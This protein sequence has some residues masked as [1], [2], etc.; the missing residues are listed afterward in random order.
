[1]TPQPR[2][3]LLPRSVPAALLATFA[4]LG[5]LAGPLPGPALAQVVGS[6]AGTVTDQVGQPLPGVK[7]TVTSPTQIGGAKTTYTNADGAFRVPGLQPGVFDVK[8]EAPKLQTVVQK[9]VVVDVGVPAEVDVLMEV[10]GA[11]EEIT[12]RNQAPLVS[13]TSAKQREAYDPGFIEK[14]PLAGIARNNLFA[15]VA[16]ATPGAQRNGLE[17]RVRGGA[18]QHN[19]ARV[20]GFTLNTLNAQPTLFKGLATME[21]QSA[22]Y[23]AENADTLGSVVDTVTKSGSNRLEFEALAFQDSNNRWSLFREK[24]EQTTNTSRT[25]LHLAASGPIVKDRVWVATAAELRNQLQDHERD[26][27]GLIDTG[28]TRTHRHAR[29]SVKLTW[30]ISPRNKVQSITIYNREGTRFRLTDNNVDVEAQLKWDRVDYLQGVTWES[31]LRDDLFF[32]TQVGV[33]GT[34]IQEYPQSCVSNPG[35][36]LDV[37]AIEQRYPRTLKLANFERVSQQTDRS[38]ELVNTLEWYRN[39]RSFGDHDLKLVSRNRWRLFET[40]QSAPGGRK[41]IYNGRAPDRQI[42]YF[43][44][45]PRLEEPRYGFAIQ[46]GTGSRWN[47]SLQDTV[48]VTRY[49]TAVVGLSAIHNVGRNSQM[50]VVMQGW[51]LTPHLSAIWDATHDGRTALRASVAQ[52]ADADAERIANQALGTGVTRECRWDE[53]TGAFSRD[54]QYAGGRP[55]RTIGLPCGPTGYW[56]DGTPCQEKLR[57]PRTW[58][59]TAGAEREIWNG[60]GAALD[61]V[62]RVF[63]NPFEFRETNRI[64]NGAGTSLTRGASF[65]NGAPGTVEDLTTESGA[66][67]RYLGVTA[68]LRRRQGVLRYTGSYTW[69][70]LQGNARSDYR[71]T[72]LGDIGPRDAYLWGY[73][74][75]DRRHEVRAA[76]SLQATSWLSTGF[77]YTYTSGGPYSR[78]YRNDVTGRYD[79]YRAAAGVDP[80]RNINDP[81]DDRELRL[82]DQQLLNLQLRA[83]LKAMVRADVELWLDVFNVLSLRTSTDVVNEDGPAFGLSA[84]RLDPMSLRLGVQYRY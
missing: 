33:V 34:I 12:V 48:R 55:N 53:Q 38:V 24:G 84:S 60:V 82:P 31:L 32:K 80:G 1:M 50:G 75:E 6:I 23:G 63:N 26:P 74:P 9:N 2:S 35:A 54:C 57:I 44:N 45:D 40:A 27:L 42:E 49:W 66:R 11:T 14:L 73:L 30:Q 72:E 79:D 39:T 25:E 10:Q 47:L 78:K 41:I 81:A 52:Y 58:E 56:P 43:S 22:A 67:R 61:G 16:A 5:A 77:M 70:R 46:G 36:C 4:L 71:N 37:P 59:Y 17:F 68:T 8:V 28:P 15:F 65:R 64:W 51:A 69:S 18:P 20:E 3:S 29:T 13:T 21:V 19:T 62:Y 83:N 7:V 76:L